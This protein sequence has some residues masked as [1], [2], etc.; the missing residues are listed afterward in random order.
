MSFKK[1]DID[2][3][4]LSSDPVSSPI[5]SGDL[6]R[7]E[8]AYTS[9]AQ[10]EGF[11]GQYY[12][13]VYDKNPEEKVSG[14]TQEGSG[15]STAKVQFSIAYAD[16]DGSGSINYNASEECDGYSPSRTVYGQYRSMVL[17]DEDDKFT[18][19]TTV[20]G[21]I[22]EES[23]YFF[24][25]TLDRA[26]FKEKLIP[27]TLTLKL[28][29]SGSDR[30]ISI[31]DNS[32]EV[33]SVRY[34]DSGRV[35][36]LVSGSEGV[37][38]RSDNRSYGPAGTYGYLLPDIGVLLI[39]G[40]ALTKENV[41]KDSEGNDIDWGIGWDESEIRFSGNAAQTAA[42]DNYTV[43]AAN[44]FEALKNGKE[45]SPDEG[46]VTF[47]V[48]SEETVTSNYI[49]VRV[50]NSEFNYSTNPS[51]ITGSGELRH[52]IMI[53]SPQAYI[54]T[55]GLYNDTNDLLAVAK[56][57]RPLVKDFTKE[58]LIRVKLNY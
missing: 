22:Q 57:S 3:I 11:S 15:V 47:T 56:L 50:K 17:G 31:T 39:N 18:F 53:N 13:D 1:F 29:Q 48:Q 32:K 24:A 19:G 5:W 12:L 52:S 16:K 44:F 34:V 35:Y 7:L 42:K 6:A 27:G 37:I 30:C 49:F 51:N 25:I 41:S 21:S 40:K 14:S 8:S 10:K 43:N 9:S 23:K 4:V 38:Y 2:D 26:R 45:G 54:T 58:A 46:K 33:G 55:V 28:Y 20:S 36:D